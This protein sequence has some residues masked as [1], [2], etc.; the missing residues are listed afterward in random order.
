[1]N[2][3]LPE[4]LTPAD[5]DLRDFTFMPL[6][7]VRLRDS[8]I[9]AVSSGDEF[10][11]AVL[12]WCASW[13]QVPAASIPDDDVILS[14]LAGYGRVVK[15]WQKVR[16]GALRGWVKCVDGRLYHPVVAE[17]ANEAWAGRLEHREKKEADRQRKAAARAAKKAQEDAE[18]AAQQHGQGPNHP[19]DKGDLSSGQ[20]ANVQRTNAG[21][22]SENALKERGTVERDSGQLT[23]TPY[24][25][26]TTAQPELRQDAEQRGAVPSEETTAT[27][28]QLCIAMRSFGINADPGNM[29]MRK[30]AADGVT[31]ETMQAACEEAK[32]SKPNEAIGPNYVIGIITRWAKEAAA[33]D[34]TGA[35]PPAAPAA[36][37]EPDWAWKKSNSGIDAKGRELRMFARNGESYPDFANRIQAELDKRKGRAA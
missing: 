19:E 23:T 4:P 25:H 20:T 26:T 30:L 35:A 31:V 21:N 22:P 18:L 1:M 15:E 17:K 10:R 11:C 16:K 9:A 14:Q 29:L 28:G 33:L 7:V 27:V 6:D 2:S 3:D 8:D 24:D 37:A 32:R 5:C 34:A 13:H 36:R 12:L